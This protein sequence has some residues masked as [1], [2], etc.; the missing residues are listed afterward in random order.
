MRCWL[1]NKHNSTTEIMNE[2]QRQAYL[3]AMGIQ[4]YYPR[5]PLAHARPSPA[6]EWPD[7]GPGSAVDNPARAVAAEPVQEK[8]SSRARVVVDLDDSRRR[9][10]PG[11]TAAPAPE[12]EVQADA[13]AAN[14]QESL[15][16]RLAYMQAAPELAV[17]SELPLHSATDNGQVQELLGNILLALSVNADTSNWQAEQ[18]NWPLSD[19]MPAAEATEEH[20]RQALG[21]FITMRQQRDGFSNLL[22]FSGR[23]GHL[24]PGA[25]RGQTSG[26]FP[27]RK[28]NCQVTCVENLQAMLSLPELKKEVWQQLQALRQRLIRN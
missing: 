8:A 3:E 1:T 7:S 18:F 19:A 14:S 22:V 28:L 24:L 4:V 15:Q 26:D 21:G 6:Y 11:E 10:R 2:R 25:A 17:L 27:A 23:L 16:F 12:P 20:A 13:P 9:R 5:Q